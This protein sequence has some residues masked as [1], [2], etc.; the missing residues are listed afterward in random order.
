MIKSAIYL[1]Y[2]LKTLIPGRMAIIIVAVKYAR[3]PVPT[4]NTLWAQT[5]KPNDP[6]AIIA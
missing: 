5:I 6:I 4:V 1:E 3:V 2:L